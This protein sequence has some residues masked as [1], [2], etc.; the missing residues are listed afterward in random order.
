M[1]YIVNHISILHDRERSGDF[2]NEE[3]H[4]LVSFFFRS[5]CGLSGRCLLERIITINWT[6]IFY[7]TWLFSWR[8]YN[9]IGA[10]MDAKTT[11]VIHILGIK[12]DTPVAMIE[13]SDRLC[14][15]TG[16]LMVLSQV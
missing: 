1:L 7:L 11:L 16:F 9:L 8:E 4:V 5:F 3:L 10:Y 2:V 14:P 15:L 12:Q 13:V 6:V